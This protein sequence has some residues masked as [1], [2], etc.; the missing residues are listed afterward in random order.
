LSGRTALQIKRYGRYFL[1][2]VALIAIGT[3][4]GAY[5]LLQQRL[6]NPFQSFYQVNGAFSSAAAVV[7]GLGE[8]VNVAG[9]H[10]GEILDTTLANGHGIIHMEIDPGKMPH[11][12]NNAHA[13]LVP[14]TPLDDMQVNIDPGTASAGILP[15]GATIKVGMTTTPTQSDDLLDAL[16]TDARTWFTSLITEL[17]HGTQGRGQD[18]RKLLMNLGPTARQLRTIGDLL[19]ARRGELAALVHNLGLLTQATS[20]KDQQIQEVITAGNTT[21]QALATQDV[22]LRAA[23][24]KLPGTL[25]TTRQTLVE[26]TSFSG[27]LAPTATALIPTAQKLPATL[28]DAST[29]VKGTALLPLN[30]IPGFE[31]VVLPLAGQL[32]PI[33]SSL[34]RAIPPLTNSFKALNYITNELAY[35]P[36]GRNPGFLY[37]LAWFAHNTDSFLS[38]SDANGPA[39]RS[40]ILTDCA[41]LKGF[42]F[43]PLLTG[44]LGTTFGC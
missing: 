4:C 7:P 16:D 13:D 41:S 22:A 15:S 29:V 24:A 33:A 31:N 5:I 10:V 19:A 21:V 42:S 2:L 36:G 11:L 1:I 32:A 25:Q 12:Y 18:L 35:N 3:V 37:W 20:A 30:K 26:L 28:R 6:P 17:N 9:V 8:P 14:N 39:W 34:T 23:I 44:L 27:E 43:G 38:T 40:L